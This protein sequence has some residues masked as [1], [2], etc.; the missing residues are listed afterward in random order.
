MGERTAKEK[1][2]R[3]LLV[4]IHR[5]A[6]REERKLKEKKKRRGNKKVKSV[7]ITEL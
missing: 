7:R 1:A 3:E 2:K 4:C 5:R 6:R